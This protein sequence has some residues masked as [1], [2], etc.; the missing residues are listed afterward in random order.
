MPSKSNYGGVFVSSRYTFLL[1]SFAVVIGGFLLSSAR[2]QTAPAGRSPLIAGS[3]KLNPEKSNIRFP[4]ENIE[5]RQ[6][7]MRPDGFLVG[8]L[9][10]GNA[11]A[12]HYLQFTAKSD[13]KDYPEYS[14]QIVADMIATGRATPRTYSETIIDEYTTEW[15]DKADGRVT[16]SG[17]KIVSQDGKTLT[18]T[19]NG[20]PLQRIYDR[21]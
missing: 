4:S 10:T 13:G 15:T 3:W 6:Y 1:C 7:R 5:I 2:S 21:Q 19:T 16:A 20:S 12:Y 14:D 17:R 18:I 9:L 11:Q 8:L